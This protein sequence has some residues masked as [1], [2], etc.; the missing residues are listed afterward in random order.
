MLEPCVRL[1]ECAWWWRAVSSAFCFCSEAM[2]LF[3]C[4]L[5][6]GVHVCGWTHAVTGVE[7]RGQREEDGS[8]LPRCESQGLN[9][10]GWAWG[11]V[12]LPAE[13]SSQ[14]CAFFWLCHNSWS[15]R[16]SH[17]FGHL[18][19]LVNCWG[20]FFKKDKYVTCISYFPHCCDKKHWAKTNYGKKD[21]LWFKN[22][23]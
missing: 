8:L 9:S 13:P 5:P 22:R 17:T 6:I 10:G 1:L 12:P 7:V 14:L 3:V 4:S 15:Q 11:Q 16:H 19:A 20:L 23:I 2:Y 18:E 21:L